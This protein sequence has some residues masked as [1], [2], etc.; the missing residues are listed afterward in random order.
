M[1][2]IVKQFTLILSRPMKVFYHFALIL[3]FTTNYLF[4]QE[5]QNSSSNAITDTL[6]EV[7]ITAYPGKLSAFT[8]PSSVALLDSSI[9]KY[10][11]Q[12]ELLPVVNSI[13]GVRMEERSPGSYRFSIRGSLLRSPFGVR[14]VKVYLEEY[15]LTDAGGNTYL[16]MLDFNDQTSL[17]IIKGP[18]GSLFGANTGGVIHILPSGA[19]TDTPS[20]I[21]LSTGSYGLFTEQLS[22]SERFGPHLRSIQQSFQRSDGYRDNSAMRRA[23]I[24]LSDRWQYSEKG[25]LKLFLFAANMHYETPGG[26]NQM[27]LEFNPRS[28]RYATPTLPGSE[29]QKAGVYLKSIFMGANHRYE[30]NSRLSHKI[31]IFG[32]RV[33]FKNPFITNYEIRGENTYGLRTSIELVSKLNS[34]SLLNWNWNT[35]LEWQ[36]TAA[37]INNYDNNGGEKGN[38]QSG[39]SILSTQH[40]Y[41]TRFQ[42]IWFNNWVVEGSVSLTNAQHVFK[43]VPKLQ[44]DF[45]P[46]WMPRLASSLRLGRQVLL[47]ASVSRGY[48]PPTTAEVLPS[49]NFIYQNLKPESGWNYEAGLRFNNKRLKIDLAA[50]H[51]Q[52]EDAIVRQVDSSGAEFFINSGGTNQNGIECS[53]NYEL[54]KSSISRTLIHSISLF[55]STT[56]NDFK[57]RDYFSSEDNFSGNKLTGVPDKVIV[58]GIFIEFQKGFSLSMMHTYVGSLPLN[59]AN[60]VSAKSYD[61][62]QVKIE[63]SFKFGKSVINLNGGV[64]N[65]LNARYSSGNDI[66]AL[67]GRYY[68][69]APGR[70]FVVSLKLKL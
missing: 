30:F 45:D 54:I 12:S 53:I 14:N 35:G 7:I 8:S 62:L 22:G 34:K 20:E 60:S 66:N 56:I 63:K 36:Q 49:N 70:N 26:L 29:A 57:F 37:E 69:P 17:E 9:M 68:N 50:F 43:E 18:D 28:A 41:F 55:N 4:S 46:Q 59:D 38:L 33:D 64:D 19:N 67:G 32:S 39:S 21:K 6:T 65:L 16:N 1:I 61:L 13:P 23:T 10:R 40:F 5:I 2:P 27:Q 48:S 25:T 15:P 3:L 51:Y 52:L 44:T 11:L 47:R 42:S 58:S 31:S 24:R